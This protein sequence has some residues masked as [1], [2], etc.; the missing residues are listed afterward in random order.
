MVFFQNTI[1]TNFKGG[2]LIEGTS[3]P[4]GRIWCTNILRRKGDYVS[5]EAVVFST[6]F[7]A[8][9]EPMM[10]QPHLTKNFIHKMEKKGMKMIRLSTNLQTRGKDL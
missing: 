9:F 2:L 1:E 3:D 6:N 7:Q 10:F 5:F 8:G 4:P